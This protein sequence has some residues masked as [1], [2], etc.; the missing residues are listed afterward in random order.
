MLFLFNVNENHIFS[1]LDLNVFKV[2]LTEMLPTNYVKKF[3]FK[4]RLFPKKK[5]MLKKFAPPCGYK[6]TAR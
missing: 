2:I 5:L 6:C 1:K 3:I 4:I